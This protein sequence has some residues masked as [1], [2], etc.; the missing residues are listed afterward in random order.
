M[1]LQDAFNSRT[2]PRLDGLA[3]ADVL[4]LLESAEIAEIGLHPL[5]SNYVF[6]LRLDAGLPGAVPMLAVYKPQAGE[7]PLR[8]F[9]AGT[10]YLRER[11]AYVLS[12]ALGWPSIPP[13][14]L[15]DGPHGPGSVQLFI[16]ADADDNFFTLRD[17]QIDI[18]EPVAAFDVLAHNADR[19]GG[20]CLR[21]AA[22][23]LWAI[24]Q[25]LTFNPMARRRTVM[26]EFCGQPLG[27]A[28]VG[29][30]RALGPKLRDGEPLHKELSSLL[31]RSEVD[32][33]RDR[34]ERIVEEPVFPVLDE[35]RNVP[36]PLL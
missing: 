21:D 23:R 33:L 5:G 8:D 1:T 35:Y 4:H 19:K 34:L 28:L 18:F 3:E 16:H 13:T 15:R 9:P 30:L 27:P 2:G 6:M 26:F 17:E 29:D 11:A 12:R 31:S 36:W 32:A 10:L 7:R 22:G 24:D 25:G 14:A 20:A